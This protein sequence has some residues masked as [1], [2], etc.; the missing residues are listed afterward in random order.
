M[1]EATKIHKIWVDNINKY[2]DGVLVPDTWVKEIYISSGVKKPIYVIPLVTEFLINSEITKTKR[3]LGNEEFFVFGMN[4]Y[5]EPRKNHRETILAFIK[6]FGKNKKVKL[7]I[8]SKGGFDFEGLR[9]EFKLYDNVEFSFG[10]LTQDELNSWYESIDSYI[11]PSSGEGFSLTPR[12]TAIREIPTIITNWSAHKTLLDSNGY[13][14]IE[15]TELKPAY[16]KGCLM[17]L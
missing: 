5:L 15:V 11:L 16:Q 8:H 6:A 14:P 9:N 10:I 13:L 12:E 3:N 4:C 2:Y 1:Y 7:K 17:N